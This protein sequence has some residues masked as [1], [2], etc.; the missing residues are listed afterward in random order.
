MAVLVD[1]RRSRKR[2]EGDGKEERREGN[3]RSNFFTLLISAIR[4]RDQERG[5]ENGREIGEE[6]IQKS[7][8]ENSFISISIYDR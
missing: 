3:E 4:G 5:E 8:W 2:R 1:L 7:D 6:K